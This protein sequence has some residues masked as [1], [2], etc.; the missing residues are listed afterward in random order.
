[1]LANVFFNTRLTFAVAF[2]LSII[3]RH[4]KR[5]TKRLL[6]KEAL[7]AANKV[8]KNGYSMRQQQLSIILSITFDQ[9]MRKSKKQRTL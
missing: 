1:M 9:G 3:A 7:S 6:S 5:K 2:D 4:R 8:I